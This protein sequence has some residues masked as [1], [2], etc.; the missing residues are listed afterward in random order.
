M[1][2]LC[3]PGE[4]EVRFQRRLIIVARMEL[5]KGFP[6]SWTLELNMA[7]RPNTYRNSNI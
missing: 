3:A 6:T 5:S 2:L 7:C 1:T 4:E